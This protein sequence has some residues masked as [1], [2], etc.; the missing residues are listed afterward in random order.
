MLIENL[1][2]GSRIKQSV[3]GIGLN[4]NQEDFPPSLPNATSVKQ[5]L[6]HD[7]DILPILSEICNN[8]EAWYLRLKAGQTA[9]VR[10]SYLNRLY[11]LNE[12][13]SFRSN[14]DVFEGTISNVKDNGVLVINNN[15][16]TELEFTFKQIEF[17]R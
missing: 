9:L 2:H 5:I 4:I 12:S 16:E 6:H 1:L 10:E 15:F 7:Y 14:G 13:H 3:I 11:W 8:I 17:I